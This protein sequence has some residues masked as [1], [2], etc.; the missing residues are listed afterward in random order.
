MIAAPSRG[1]PNFQ[2]GD[3]VR[4]KGSSPDDKSAVG[5]VL[6]VWPGVQGTDSFTYDI[7]FEGH[8]AMYRQTQLVSASSPTI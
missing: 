5:T 2:V 6:S 7:Q 3:K 1:T 4:L 8:T